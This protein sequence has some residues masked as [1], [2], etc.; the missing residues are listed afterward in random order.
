ME[1]SCTRQELLDGVNAVSKAVSARPTMPILS[2]IYME[3]QENSLRFLATDMELGI[4]YTIPIRATKP[5]T[6]VVNAKIFN[7]MVRRLPDGP[8][9]FLLSEDSSLLKVRYFGS[10]LSLNTM[11]PIEFPVLPHIVEGEHVT[12]TQGQFKEMTRLVGFSASSDESRP[13]FT[14]ILWDVNPEYIRWVATD[15]HRL[16]FLQGTMV[17]STVQ[18]GRQFILHAKTL[19]DVARLLHEEEN[20]IHLTIT[21]SQVLIETEQ[22]RVIL[23]IIEGQYPK[24][25]QVIPKEYKCRMTVKVKALL[26]A[27]D[28]AA[29]ASLGKEG[30]N[31][32]KIS[33]D[34]NIL[35]IRSNS[36]EV[37]HIHEEVFVDREGDSISIAFNYR[38]LQE[39]LKVFSVEDIYIDLTGPLVPGVIR[40]IGEDRY[41]YLI[42]PV[43][44]V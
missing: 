12:L 7:E 19:I 27:V 23:R 41:L 2:G 31:I 6:T 11:N 38:Y 44:T 28:R 22:M 30:S 5:G 36:P 3:V 35:T 37:G 18:E 21:K 4:E 15:T 39:A 17:S 1:F 10:E 29:L 14:G 20:P 26:E 16:S 34:G 43:R 40:P 25:Q 33:M 32:I 9:T 8:I 13:W 42:V 24:Y